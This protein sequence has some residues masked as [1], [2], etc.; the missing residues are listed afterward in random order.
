[1]TQEEYIKSLESE[2][3]ECVVCP[4]CKGS[5]NVWWLLGKYYGAHHPCDDLAELESCENCDGGVTLMCS[6]CAELE[7][8]DSLDS[9]YDEE[10]S[11]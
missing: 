1:M 6:R 7:Y 10:I 4:Y 11:R 2:P 8:Y 5:G 9:G 3:C